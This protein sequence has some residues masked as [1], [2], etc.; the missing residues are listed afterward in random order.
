MTD[1]RPPGRAAGR[2]AAARGVLARA[3]RVRCATAAFAGADTA[4]RACFVVLA[5]GFA[6]ASGFVLGRLPAMG[7]GFGATTI[8][9]CAA[10]C[11][12]RAGRGAAFDSRATDADA[13]VAG[14]SL[15]FTRAGAAP[16]A[17]RRIGGATGFPAGLAT[18][19]TFA[20]RFT[21]TDVAVFVWRSPTADPL[22]APARRAFDGAAAMAAGLGS[23]TAALAT[24]DVAF[25]FAGRVAGCV[26][27]A[28]RT[29]GVRPPS[30]GGD[31]PADGSATRANLAV[32][33]V[34]RDGEFLTT[35]T[36]APDGGSFSMRS[37][38]GPE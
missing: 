15:L 23:A 38:H 12:T 17:L 7:F 14:R 28:A 33:S 4:P 16:L 3:G 26:A 21:G 24:R 11:F 13:R 18:A 31:A 36:R 8:G 2:A 9:R 37:S 34:A 19:A 32:R 1:A 25:A 20:P 29:S 10:A 5:A 35:F 6:T 22:A 30:R 27:G